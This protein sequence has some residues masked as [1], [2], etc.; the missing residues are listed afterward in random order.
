MG[1]IEGVAEQAQSAWSPAYGRFARVL[2]ERNLRTGAEIGVAFGGHSES[3]LE[4][5]SVETLYG[6]DPYTRRADYEDIKYAQSDF[7]E[8]HD[9]AIER[10]SVF[11]P[12]F[13]MI[14]ALSEDAVELVPDG[15]DFVYVDA[16]HSCPAV[17]ADLCHWYPK[18]RPGGVIGGHDYDHPDLP[19]VKLAVDEF[20]SRL[21][22]TAHAEGEG[23]W[24]TERPATPARVDPESF[25]CR[26]PLKTRARMAIARM[27]GRLR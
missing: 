12:R 23:V 27:L 9:F 2:R 18:I 13:Q 5:T 24:W 4:E 19:D 16:D 3:I 15:L 10:L 26:H 14:R 25:D 1:S 7:D 22:T 11:G 21:G 6:V 20:C 17:W 8:I